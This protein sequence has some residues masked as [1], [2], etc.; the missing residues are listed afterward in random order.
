MV[1]WVRWLVAVVVTVV[2]YFV[3]VWVFGVLSFS[4]LPRVPADR[5]VVAAG[6]ATVTGGA[7]FGVLGVWAG[8]EDPDPGSG[9]GGSGGSP[10]SGAPVVSGGGDHVEFH[11][12]IHG[13]VVGKGT[14]HN[15]GRGS[16]ER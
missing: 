8:R 14:Q 2:V 7:V 1:W 13:P 6:F 5:W 3:C 4:W 11:G 9:G 12:P 10:V 15:T 16:G